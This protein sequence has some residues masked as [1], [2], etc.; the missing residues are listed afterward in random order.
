M[1]DRLDFSRPTVGRLDLRQ[2][3]SYMLA[4]AERNEEDD[5]AC[6]TRREDALWLYIARYL[7]FYAV[8][9]EHPRSD[10]DL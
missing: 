1:H 4:R 8:A 6:R 10:Q 7:Q 9:R 5:Q 3:A 2:R